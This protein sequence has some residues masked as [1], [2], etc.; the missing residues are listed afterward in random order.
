MSSSDSDCDNCDG[1]G[2]M[3]SINFYHEGGTQE[4]K[5]ACEENGRVDDCC[6]HS[7]CPKCAGV[8]KF[9]K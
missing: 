7:T 6:C 8:G 1:Y 2:K 9:P 3:S 4:E 5:D